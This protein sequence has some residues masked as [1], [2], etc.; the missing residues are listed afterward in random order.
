MYR[1]V[2]SLQMCL[3][4]FHALRRLGLKTVTYF[5]RTLSFGLGCCAA[6]LYLL[7]LFINSCSMSGP[8]HKGPDSGQEIYNDGSTFDRYNVIAVICQNNVCRLASGLCCHK[9]SLNPGSVHDRYILAQN[10]GHARYQNCQ[11]ST[12]CMS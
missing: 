5:E 10:N 3:S 2:Y 7:L 6:A 11:T 9:P 12:C 1:K 4:N 8:C